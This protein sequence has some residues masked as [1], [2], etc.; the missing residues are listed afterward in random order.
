MDIEAVISVYRG[1][2]KNIGDLGAVRVDRGITNLIKSEGG[3]GVDDGKEAS[4][5]V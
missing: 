3:G 5:G 4:V 1:L 2:S